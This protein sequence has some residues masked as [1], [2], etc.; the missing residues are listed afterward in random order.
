[1]GL[2][3]DSSE[4]DSATMQRLVNAAT[5]RFDKPEDTVPVV[6]LPAL[7]SATGRGVYVAELHHGPT[8]AFKDLGLS[9]LGR[10]MD[11][12]L[13]HRRRHA[14]VLVGTSGDTGSSAIHGVLGCPAIDIV[15]MYP[16]GG[17][18]SKVQERQMTTVDDPQVHVLQV[19]GTS[20][21]LDV[22]I[23]RV[24]LGGSRV[25][26]HCARRALLTRIHFGV[27]V[28]GV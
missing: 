26:V 7:S 11:Y 10:L 23:K 5:R 19:D 14:T 2:F 9:V 16:G 12:F 6:R 8:L 13:T 3:I 20:D 18:I 1:M 4:I 22:V 24:R 17:R 15:V 25:G 28:P 21:D 27:S